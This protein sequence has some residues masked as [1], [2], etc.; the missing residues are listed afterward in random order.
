M[1]E[2]G[3]AS[4]SI[5]ITEYG[6]PDTGVDADTQARLIVDSAQQWGEVP[7]GGPFYVYTVRDGDSASADSEARFGVLDDAFV[8]KPV[9]G[10][11][12]ALAAAGLPQRDV[13][14]RFDAAATPDLGEPLG[15][16]FALS[17]GAGRQYARGSLYS[18]AGGWLTSPPAVADI[19]RTTGLVPA[20]PF[21][22]GYQD[23]LADGGFRV[24]SHPQFGTWAV[25][26]A[27]LDQWRPDLGSPVTGEYETPDGQR[28]V[29]FEFGRIL[30]TPIDGAVVV[31]DR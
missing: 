31:R 7:Y 12:A 21:R 6:A 19:A 30:W 18:T 29:D 27:I 22:D 1:V 26:G 5:W 28:V 24:F 25:V 2:R 15:P 23:L 10:Q 8:P 9:Y 11:L 17:A 3:D 13:A 4:A 16:V 20:G 14:N